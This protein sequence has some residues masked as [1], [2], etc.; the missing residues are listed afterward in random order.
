MHQIRRG[1]PTIRAQEH[2]R[3]PPRRRADLL[4]VHAAHA[5]DR[6]RPLAEVLGRTALA[7]RVLQQVDVRAV[8][9][10]VLVQRPVL[11]DVG[12]TR[13]RRVVGDAGQAGWRGTPKELDAAGWHIAVRTS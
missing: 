13:E 9:G 11:L 10:V 6:A 2:D 3:G 7:A 4:Y 1:R 8:A 12:S 5:V